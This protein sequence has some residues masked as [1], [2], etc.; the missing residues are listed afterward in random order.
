MEQGFVYI[1]QS[2]TSNNYY[3]GSSENPTKRLS[4][5]NRGKVKSTRN[6]GPWILKFTQGFPTIKEAKQIEYMIKKLKRRDY[7]ER[8][9]QD[10]YIKMK[11]NG[12]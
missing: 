4:E 3:T 8:I 12:L 1:I 2:Q 10:G 6:K 9:I 7:L 5:H 11:I